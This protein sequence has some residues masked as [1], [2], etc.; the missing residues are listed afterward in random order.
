MTFAV[1]LAT[2]GSVAV[3]TIGTGV[4]GAYYSSLETIEGKLKGKILGN[5]DTF[6]SSWDYKQ[7]KLNGDNTVVNA[8]L[9]KIK[10]SK[11]G[12][13]LS[14]YCHKNYSSTYKS[15]FSGKGNDSLLEETKKWCTQ[16][17]KDQL[18]INLKNSGKVLNVDSDSEDK[19]NFQENFKK[20]KT[21]N[22]KTDGPL[23]EK[24]K[25]LSSTADASHE[26]N[27]QHLRSYCKEV[28]SKYITH[29]TLE[30]FKVAKKYCV[31]EGT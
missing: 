13:N 14:S 19:S 23:T 21:H 15:I 8:A 17:F 11:D 22:E 12:S 6:K 26:N 2:V 5:Y 31:K 10:K 20:L 27:W 24:L 16:T 30:D 1:K 29:E 3:G 28:H 18:G 25:S 7:Q 9:K 4:G